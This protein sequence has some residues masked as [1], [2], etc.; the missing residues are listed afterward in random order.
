MT[1][2]RAVV[3]AF[4][5]S[6]TSVVAQTTW[7]QR[8][9]PGPSARC[10]TAMA[11]DLARGRMV[12]FGGGDHLAQQSDT[13]EWDGTTWTLIPTPLGPPA[14]W[15]HVMAYDVQ[16]G[17]AGD[18]AANALGVVVSNGGEAGLALR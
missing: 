10:G 8:Q 15:R 4:A 18:P 12:L 9:V 17:A 1:I 16:R 11:Y 2:L 7:Q 13:W 6:A 5:V 3:S 14:R